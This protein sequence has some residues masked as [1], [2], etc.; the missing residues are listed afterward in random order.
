MENAACWSR[1]DSLPRGAWEWLEGGSTEAQ[2]DGQTAAFFLEPS[3]ALGAP[4]R[5]AGL[6]G[7]EFHV[8]VLN[9]KCLGDIPE[10]LLSGCWMALSEAHF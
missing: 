9:L 4:G 7:T 10:E 8:A 3:V 1:Q 6:K 2:A 5:A